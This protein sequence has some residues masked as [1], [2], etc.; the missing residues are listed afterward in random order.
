[1]DKVARQRIPVILGPT[2]SGKTALSLEL[3][4]ALDAEIISADSRQIYRELDIGTAKPSK[5]ELER[6]RHHFIDERWVYEPY[7]AGT[8]TEEATERIASI[9]QRKKRVVVVGGSTL[10]LQ[11]LLKGFSVLPK[12][13]VAIRQRLEEALAQ[14]GGEVLYQRLLQLDPEQA[15][16]L[17][18]TKTQR[19]IRSLEVIEV[20]GETMS[21]LKRKRSFSPAFDFTVFGLDLPREILYERI[22]RRTDEMM[23]NGF[24]E[25]ARYLFNKYQE[26]LLKQKINAFETVGYKELFA[27]LRGELPLDRAVMLI[28]QHTRNYAKR[29]LTFFRNQFDVEWIKAPL[30]KEDISLLA[31]EIAGS[32]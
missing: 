16:T 1:M 20:S 4:G 18:P 26:L 17:D 11:G 24:L 14:C 10:Y 22:N 31:Q 30:G 29:Q 7:D 5:H 15:A 23:E 19:L 6:V 3:A 28:K 32:V 2:A 25:E 9:V 21:A 27:C 8:F 13:D 12:A